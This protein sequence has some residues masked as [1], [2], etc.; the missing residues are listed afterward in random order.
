MSVIVR[1]PAPLRSLT[2][3]DARIEVDSGT[4]SDVIETLE[5]RH[6]GLKERLLDENG[7]R[8]FVNL[9]AGDNDIRFLDGLNTRLSEG[10]ELS[11]IP[12]IAGG[13]S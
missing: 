2:G 4:V 1:I 6:P 7:V 9:Y 11:I 8:R 10:D 5:R 12:A 13:A 3:G